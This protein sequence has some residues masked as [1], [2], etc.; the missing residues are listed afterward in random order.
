MRKISPWLTRILAGQLA[1]LAMTVAAEP[2]IIVGPTE[3]E[4][5]VEVAEG[6]ELVLVDPA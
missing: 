2:R 3:A 5:E 1:S 4:E 6:V